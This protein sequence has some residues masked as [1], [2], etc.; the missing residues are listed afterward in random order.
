VCL[1]GPEYA[2]L[3]E[4]FSES[5]KIQRVRDGSVK[6]M[7]IFFGGTDPTNETGK[8][9]RAV[10]LLKRNEITVDVVVGSRNPNRHQIEAL[11][12]TMPHVNYY[13][14]IDHIADLMSKA[15]ISIGACGTTAWERCFLG[16]PAITITIGAN[17]IEVAKALDKVG[18]VINLGWHNAVTAEMITDSISR[19]LQQP[20]RLKVMSNIGLTLVGDGLFEVVHMI[21][22][23]KG[24]I[25]ESGVNFLG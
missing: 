22:N 6:R 4:E 12:L 11:C 7:L 19:L 20:E 9:L 2:L 18:A 5:R 1:L 8:A 16:L 10:Q 21:K 3:R 23:W 17:Q 13:C 25:S 15:D 14:Q 24:T